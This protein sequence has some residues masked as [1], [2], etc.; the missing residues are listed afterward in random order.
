[1]LEIGHQIIKLDFNKVKIDK[2]KEVADC[3]YIA[4]RMGRISHRDAIQTLARIAC[5]DD[6]RE[7]GRPLS[8]HGDS[9]V[10]TGNWSKVIKDVI[11]IH[12]R[13]TQDH[14][15]PGAIRLM[16]VENGLARRVSDKFGERVEFEK[17][18][19]SSKQKDQL[20]QCVQKLEDQIAHDPRF[21]EKEL[22]EDPHS[23]GDCEDSV[24]IRNPQ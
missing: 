23:S 5:I 10:S 8:F 24:A 11:Y 21:D 15:Y 2:V 9:W 6:A 16:L 13:V 1:V 22:L 18:P 4:W 17:K 19:L 7:K 12:N 20:I 3:V 14:S